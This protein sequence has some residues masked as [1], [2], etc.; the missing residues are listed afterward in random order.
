MT[1]YGNWKRLNYN[2]PKLG[3]KCEWILFGG[4]WKDRGVGKWFDNDNNLDDNP[5][6]SS[7]RG[8]YYEKGLFVSDPKRTIWRHYD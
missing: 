2:K 1:V 7:I 3:Q 8:F 5:I 4:S 6:K